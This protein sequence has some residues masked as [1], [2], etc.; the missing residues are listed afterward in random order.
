MPSFPGAPP[1]Q[2]EKLR[3]LPLTNYEDF[4]MP[5]LWLLF[6]IALISEK[7][8]ITITNILLVRGVLAYSLL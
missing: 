6:Y 7:V 8:P 5:K 3:E 4:S 1:L 2:D